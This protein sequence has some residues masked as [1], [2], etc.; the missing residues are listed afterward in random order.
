M[1]IRFNCPHCSRAL[2]TARRKSGSEIRCPLCGLPATVPADQ[3]AG[4]LVGTAVESSPP[5]PAPAAAADRPLFES[6]DVDAML[7]LPA[8]TPY[9]LVNDAPARRP[10]SGADALSLD[11]TTGKVVLGRT[12]VVWLAVAAV[13]AVALAFAIGVQV[14]A[15]W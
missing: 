11:D 4:R 9:T 7:G 5:R 6:A 12:T 10:V 15:A 2:A 1:P 3:P 8:P 14:G 13:L